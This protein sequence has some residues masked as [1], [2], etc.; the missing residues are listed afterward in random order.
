LLDRMRP[1]I[2]TV[3]AN[4]RHVDMIVRVAMTAIQRNP[5]LLDCDQ[6]SLMGAIVQAAQL[7]LEPD[8]V[9]G[10]SYLVP[11]AKR[12]TLI[13]GYRGLMFLALQTEGVRDIYARLVHAGDEF[14]V[15][16]GA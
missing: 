12:V 7:G 10:L 4:P 2:L 15:D 16:Y 6:R 9:R 8:D 3:L 1:Q 13:P 5:A 11:Y 14:D